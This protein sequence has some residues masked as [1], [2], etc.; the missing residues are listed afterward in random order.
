[1]PVGR[2]AAEALAGGALNMARQVGGD[3]K[4]VARWCAC[5][6]AFVVTVFA[7]MAIALA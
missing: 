1:M 5:A 3:A 2:D 4:E 7:G 6:T